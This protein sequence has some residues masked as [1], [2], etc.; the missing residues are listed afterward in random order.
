MVIDEED[1]CILII[2]A[3]GEGVTTKAISLVNTKEKGLYISPIEFPHHLE[4]PENLEYVSSL[5]L[6]LEKCKEFRRVKKYSYVIIDNY[7]LDPSNKALKDF[8]INGRH[9]GLD[10][11][12][13]TSQYFS[14]LD[15]LIKANVSYIYI[16]RNLSVEDTSKLAI[17]AG[18]KYQSL[19]RMLNELN[20]FE[21][22]KIDVL[23]QCITKDKPQSISLC[24]WICCL[25]SK[26]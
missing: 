2:G 24:E 18:C 1:N 22:Y 8:L 26:F 9:L 20:K 5:E 4:K 16:S 19:H 11:I 17:Y 12:I 7:V 25:P 6:G 15:P 3:R 21:F 14:R 13:F 23:E 10:N